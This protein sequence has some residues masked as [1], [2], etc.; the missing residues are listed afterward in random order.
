[1]P[2]EYFKFRGVWN[3]WYDFMGTDTS[4]Y[5]QSK[6][7]WIEFCKNKNIK[8]LCDYNKYCDIYDELPKNPGDFYKDFSSIFN[9]LGVITKRR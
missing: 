9:E 7:Q 5:I 4:K 8:T 6:Q 3:N 1:M 2:E